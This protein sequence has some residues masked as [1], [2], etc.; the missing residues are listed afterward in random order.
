MGPLETLCSSSLSVIKPYD[1]YSYSKAIHAEETSGKAWGEK[2]TRLV[3][4]HSW[5]VS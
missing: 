5:L 2:G 3:S 4:F 1:K